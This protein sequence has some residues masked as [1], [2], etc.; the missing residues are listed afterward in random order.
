[1]YDEIVEIAQNRQFLEA[2]KDGY[3]QGPNMNLLNTLQ[4]YS[5]VAH[6]EKEMDKKGKITFDTIFHEPLGYYL[7]KCFLIHELSVD[8]VCFVLFPPIILAPSYEKLELVSLF[9]IVIVIVYYI[10]I[11]ICIC[12][13]V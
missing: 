7:I 10:C 2:V 9:C 6:I 4:S 12:V 5:D 11:C 1:M 8:K 3:S 13:C